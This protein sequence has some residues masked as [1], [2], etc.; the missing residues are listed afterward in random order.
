MMTTRVK[1]S[2]LVLF[3]T[4]MA[5]CYSFK[6][7]AQGYMG[8][9][10]LFSY[11]VGFSPLGYARTNFMGSLTHELGIERVKNRRISYGVDVTY[12][13][14]EQKK[15]NE[16]YNFNLIMPTLFFR[17]HSLRKGSIAP[18]GIAN[19]LGI[20]LAAQNYTGKVAVPSSNIG[21]VFSWAVMK[22]I[23][24]SKSLLFDYG[25]GITVPL[26]SFGDNDAAVSNSFNIRLGLTF[27]T[28]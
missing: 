20:G 6:S 14:G 11:R 10:T 5:C 28:K 9:R 16:F 21:L 19:K 7:Q 1:N 27:A 25:T 4:I 3:F 23:P 24:L 13:M 22:R 15:D 26:T 2:L 17:I 12:S 18:L 8:K